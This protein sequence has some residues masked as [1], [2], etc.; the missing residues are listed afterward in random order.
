MAPVLSEVSAA[1]A[2][3]SASGVLEGLAL[4]NGRV[5]MQT[6]GNGLSDSMAETAFS[7]KW[8]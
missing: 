4:G 2:A 1:A 5:C 7:L 8:A 6:G 3:A